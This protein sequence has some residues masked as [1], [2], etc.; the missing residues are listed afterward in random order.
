MNIVILFLVLIV[1]G[2]LGLLGFIMI[3]E[4]QH[5]DKYAEF[6]IKAYYTIDLLTLRGHTLP[7]NPNCLVNDCIQIGIEQDKIDWWY[8]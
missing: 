4:Q 7:V 1:I 8:K 6:G 2:Y 3:H 5:V